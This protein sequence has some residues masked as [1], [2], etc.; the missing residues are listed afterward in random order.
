MSNNLIKMI[1]KLLGTVVLA[2]ASQA[3]HAQ[4]EPSAYPS[5]TQVSY[6]RTWDAVAPIQDPN[7]L[8]TRPVKDVK[9]ATQYLDGLGRPIQTVVKQGSS[10]TNSNV[11]TDVITA[12]V[13]DELG[14]VTYKFLPTIANNIGGNPSINDGAFKLNPFQQQKEFYSS[15]NANNPI[16]GQGESY[17]YSQ[18]DFEASPLNR[19]TKSFAQGNNWVGTKGNTTERSIGQSYL[20]NTIND[21]VV[22]W[23]INNA[24]TDLPLP[25]TQNGG[26]YAAGEL[27]KTQT[28]DEHNKQVVEFKDKAGKVILKKVQIAPSV[29]DGYT[30]WL[31]TYYIYDDFGQ[32]RFVISPKACE[33]LAQNNW[34]FANTTLGDGGELCFKYEYDAK[35][36]LIKKKVPGA[37]E[38]WM[39]YDGRDRLVLTQ[40]GNL[41]TQQKWI[42]T[43]YDEL[44]RP[45]ASGLW[46]SALTHT[47]HIS[48]AENSISYPTLSGE[49]ELSRTF[50]NN[51]DW[52]STYSTG[53]SNTYSTAYNNYFEPVSNTNW[54]YAQANV[55]TNQLR[56]VV[57][58]S[59]VKVLGTANTYLYTVNFYD[60]KGRVI[61]TQSTNNSGKIDIVTTQY[62]WAG[63]PLVVVQK[64]DL[65][66][67]YA[68]DVPFHVKTKFNYD[69]LGRVIEAK[70]T[71]YGTFQYQSIAKAEQTIAKNEYDAL[72]QLKKK[73]LGANNL[74]NLNY[75]YNIRGWMLGINKD[76]IK[77]ISSNYFA[78]ELAYD[79]TTSVAT[80]TSFAA[81]QFNGNI[82]GL[83]WKSKGDGVNRQY[84]FEYDNANRLLNAAFKQKNDDNSWNNTQMDYTVKMGDG[85][86]YTSAYDANGNIKKMQQWGWKLGGN[87]QIDNLTYN[88]IANSNKLLNVIDA[89]ND[90]TT[91]LGDFRTSTI[92]PNQTKTSTTVDYAY[93]VN[94]NLVKDLNKDIGNATTNGIV[95]NHLNL[96]QTINVKK[97]ASGNNKGIV[98][99]TYDA[100][101]N[102]L[103]KITTEENAI[104]RHN[105]VAYTTNITTTIKYI[106]SFVYESKTYTNTNLTT[107]SYTDK[108]Q[109]FG[110]EDGRVRFKSQAGST[111][112]SL[113]YDYY[114]KDNLGSVRATL[115]EEQQQDNY[116][117]ATLEPA[118]IATESIFYGNLTNTQTT[119][120][121]WFNIPGNSTPNAKVAR[122]KNAAG[123]QNI[124]PNLILK[125]MAGDSYNIQVASG[126]NSTSSATNNSTN[127]LSNLL[128]LLSTGVAGASGGKAT[129]A[130]LQ[131]TSSGLNAGL[132][133]FMGFQTTN[134]L[135]KPKA[136]ISWI[137][138]DEQFKVAKDANG[139]IMASGYSGFEQVEA[140]GLTTLH[141]KSF[142]TVAKSGYLYIYT[143][144]EA[145]NIDVYFDNLQVTHNRG[146]LLET[147]NYYSFGLLESGISYKAASGM[148]NKYKYNGKEL[149][150][151]E[152]SDG[153]GL[154]WT[155]YGARMYDQQIG[156]LQSLDPFAFKFT[157]Y[158][159]Y[160]YCINNP[161]LFIDEN[162]LEFQDP[163]D[164]ARVNSLKAEITKRRDN[165]LMW[166]N[167]LI[168]IDN[169]AAQKLV[170]D[171]M[172]SANELSS[173][174]SDIDKMIETKDFQFSL[175][176]TDKPFSHALSKS[177][178]RIEYDGTSGTLI[179]EL[180]HGS[181]YMN[182][183]MDFMVFNNADGQE[184]QAGLLYDQTDEVVAYRR[185]YALSGLKYDEA[186]TSINLEQ[187]QATVTAR[188]KN[189]TITITHIDQINTST[190][191]KIGDGLANPLYINIPS[192]YLNSQSTVS[193]VVQAN[194][195]RSVLTQ[196]LGMNNGNNRTYKNFVSNSSHSESI[197]VK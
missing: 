77:D 78:M 153:S 134:G 184:I 49:E 144:N 20:L 139:N 34:L 187:I 96:P 3:V 129:V 11:Y 160:S 1:S 16:K 115:T 165:L 71:I 66:E 28:N 72:G 136:Y 48:N 63:Q 112:A 102:K 114:I 68:E 70:K 169:D 39:V 17:F 51:Y 35:G 83:L 181:Q 61:Q 180:T 101:G 13:Y 155:D 43:Q 107:L 164:L 26:F 176:I 64:T 85:I 23:K 15:S 14:R 157:D 32:L 40:D 142:L 194:T 18:T 57:T 110:H 87:V 106:N 19:P 29:T 193:A 125:V 171:F 156:R 86:N 158:S 81:S 82:N 4:Y 55:Q 47:Q 60:E 7:A 8:L 147:A 9:Q 12:N 170:D 120:P 161:I 6:V 152:F 97:D 186:L 21:A 95:Y 69:D 185:Q 103:Q 175:G 84:D 38:V 162:G 179:H 127:V 137:L 146:A 149:Q 58:G 135:A 24:I 150:S 174:L 73:T 183:E 192:T 33:V 197:F 100:T 56:G 148:E 94:G 74:E 143:S 138:L 116:P 53:L 172:S 30:G 65:L 190:V 105:N 118:T 37:A 133:S 99:F 123:S 173:S 177:T 42:Y 44:N 22:A 191:N 27:Y 195:N 31:C 92:S 88:Y 108:L 45:I 154:E 145:T 182:G 2:I 141:V 189:P 79:K 10:I 163:N 121:G 131:N 80:G 178:V 98:S 76:Y 5:G 168:T 67:A 54:P 111:A 62:T 36:R 93:D 167:D 89:N 130:Q 25:I 91:K 113:Q 122:V 140:S 90:A 124:G 104:V 196:G 166:A 128:N 109:F 188:A 159:P 119:K 151:K 41:R 126:W 132:G 75:D 117:L 52:V 46:A 59:R 50:Y